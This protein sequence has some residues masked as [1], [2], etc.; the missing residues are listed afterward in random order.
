[1]Y[2]KIVLS[3]LV[4]F[5]LIAPVNIT[6]AAP[7]LDTNEALLAVA[8]TQVPYTFIYSARPVGTGQVKIIWK[9]VQGVDGYQL[10]YG[11]KANLSDGKY[12]AV[13]G[14]KNSYIRKNLTG[15]KTYYV[16]LRAF[17]LVNGKRVYAAWSSMKSC[18]LGEPVRGTAQIMSLTSEKKGE[19]RVVV[20]NLTGAGGYQIQY[21]GNAAFSN[22]KTASWPAS[23][24]SIYTRKDL[25]AGSTYYVRVRAYKDISGVRYYGAW[26]SVL[27]VKVRQET[28]DIDSLVR[29]MKSG[30]FSYFAGT[31]KASELSNRSYG[32]GSPLKDLILYRDGHVTGGNPIWYTGSQ[33]PTN[34]PVSVE[35]QQDG[36]IKCV[37]VPQY[38]GWLT[39]YYSIYPKGVDL[40]RRAGYKDV[41]VIQV[42]Q[43]SGGVYDPFFVKK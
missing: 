3:I 20:L 4:A 35:K 8:A 6:P 15:G 16:R 21:A 11:T 14:N 27:T 9:S 24:G 18:Y 41:D 23:K 2:K 30:D 12:A 36:G 25:K 34:R 42:M 7:G 43:A 40:P 1:M 32:G 22:V 33:L 28:V 26:S 10:K 19:M 5:L 31:Y 17:R 39:T 13:S 37:L 38:N 29:A